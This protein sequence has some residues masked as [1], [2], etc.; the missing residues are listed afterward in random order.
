[1]ARATETAEQDKWLADALREGW[2]GADRVLSRI[3]HT[4]PDNSDTE[5]VGWCDSCARAI[6]GLDALSGSEADKRQLAANVHGLSSDEHFLCG[7][8]ESG[9][10]GHDWYHA[11]INAEARE[12]RVQVPNLPHVEKRSYYHAIDVLAQK[13]HLACPWAERGEYC[14]YALKEEE[15]EHEDQKE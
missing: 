15:R 12:C 5:W 8:C 3:R 14:A 4:H 13:R 1:M 10:P 11:D 2:T 6:A 9:E 7:A